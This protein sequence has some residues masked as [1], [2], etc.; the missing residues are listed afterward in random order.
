MA[1]RKNSEETPAPRRRPATTP[2]SREN[3]LIA[4]AVDLAEKQIREGTVSSQVLTHYL[5]L[6]S[7]REKLEQERLRNENHVL[8]AKA[9]AMASA[10]KVEELYGMA[11]NAMRSYAGQDPVSLGDDFDDD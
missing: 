1:R 9:D 5:K 8:K 11:L 3:Q 7:S 6:G 4:A 10:K 2:E